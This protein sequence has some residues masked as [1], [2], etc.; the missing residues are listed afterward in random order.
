M[1]SLLSSDK[2]PI[3]EKIRK[4]FSPHRPALYH[5][6]QLTL[7]AHTTLNKYCKKKELFLQQP[8]QP[9]EKSTHTTIAPPFSRVR[10]KRK[11]LNARAAAK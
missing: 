11:N 7:T 10:V 3:R 5:S 8:Q 4:F 9:T 2:I 1:I 6:L